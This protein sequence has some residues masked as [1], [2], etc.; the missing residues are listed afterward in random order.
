MYKSKISPALVES[1]QKQYDAFK[2]PYP[3][4]K[5]SSEIASQEQQAVRTTK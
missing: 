5:L 3:A 2:V 4:D 1:F